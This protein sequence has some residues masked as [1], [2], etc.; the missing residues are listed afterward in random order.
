MDKKRIKVQIDD[1]NFHII[2]NDDEEYI[3]ELANDLNNRINNMRSSNFKL[4][5][6]QNLILLA[7]NLLDE[8]EKMK[9]EYELLQII[10]EDDDAY[11]NSLD[12]LEQLREENLKH[13][14]DEQ[15]FKNNISKLR[16]KIKSLEEDNTELRSEALNKNKKIEEMLAVINELKDE[17]NVLEQQIYDSQKRIMDLNREIENLNE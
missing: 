7:L 3:K 6:N 15:D 4:N 5:Q 12:E 17:K 10:K 8:K 2:G 11:K 1:M 13:L 16:D 14:L 9:K